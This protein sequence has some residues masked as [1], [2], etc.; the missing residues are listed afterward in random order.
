MIIRQP[1]LKAARRHAQRVGQQLGDMLDNG[2]DGEDGEVIER[3]LTAWARF[4]DQFGDPNTGDVVARTYVAEGFRRAI[5]GYRNPTLE[6]MIL[7]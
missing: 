3:L 6:L 7:S 2:H 5:S 1:Q 4:I